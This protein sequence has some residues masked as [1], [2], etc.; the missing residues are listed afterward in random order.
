[1]N[2]ALLSVAIAMLLAGIS[3]ESEAIGT[4]CEGYDLAVIEKQIADQTGKTSNWAST[5][6]YPSRALSQGRQGILTFRVL[7]GMDGYPKKCWVIVSSGHQD[8]DQAG[9]SGLLKRA[10]F[11]PATDSDGKPVEGCY[12]NRIAYLIRQ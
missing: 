10:R 12:G 4:P 3:R 9:C 7:I 6:D 5:T 2:A 1:M 11:H 8:L